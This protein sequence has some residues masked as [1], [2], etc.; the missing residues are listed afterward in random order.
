MVEFGRKP[1][2]MTQNCSIDHARQLFE[3]LGDE[4]AFK[5]VVSKNRLIKMRSKSE[6]FEIPVEQIEA[7]NGRDQAFLELWRSIDS[8]YVGRIM[9]GG[10]GEE[11]S[12]KRRNG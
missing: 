12:A 10:L 6:S 11:I 5:K 8:N 9:V 7:K 1:R 3:A 2:W 4:D